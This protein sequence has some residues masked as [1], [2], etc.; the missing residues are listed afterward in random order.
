M[1]RQ[2]SNLSR[3]TSSMFPWGKKFGEILDKSGNRIAVSG[4]FNEMV[5][6]EGIEPP[7]QGFSIPCS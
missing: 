5:A 2:D 1:N 6:R 4:G 3:L 7:T